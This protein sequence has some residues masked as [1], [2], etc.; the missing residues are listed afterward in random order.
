MKR[1]AEVEAAAAAWLQRRESAD[2]SEADDQS[3]AAWVAEDR[4]HHIAMLR[5][6][7]VWAK[8]DRL[9]VTGSHT[10]SNPDTIENAPTEW[11]NE[12]PRMTRLV[13]RWVWPAALAASIALLAVPAA[14]SLF[15]GEIYSTPVGGFQHVPLADGSQIDLNTD[16]H[17]TVEYSSTDRRISLSRG[18]AYF[19]VAKNAERPF[20]VE[21][22]DWRV[23]AV[24]TAFTVNTENENFG[25]IVTEG[26]VR[27]DRIG[28]A[29]AKDGPVYLSAGQALR[30]G[31]TS[32]T[33][34]SVRSLDARSMEAE[35][36]WREGLL[37]FEGRP[38]SEV[39]EEM[40]RYNQL[41][42][43]VDRSAADVKIDGSF[44]TTNAAGFIR[45]IEE[46]FDIQAIREGGQVLLIEKS[47]KHSSGVPE[48]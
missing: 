27:I 21:T 14:Q 24:G 11:D 12:Q 22:P 40:N 20:Y 42:M 18:E 25:V 33:T 47:K 4:A 1:A 39:A 30:L 43:R 8:V 19:K 45:L 36:G 9:R 37:T 23:T 38:L 46:G 5:L 2:W 13:K 31:P 10:S 7:S 29:G 32:N 34:S 17:L 35:L 15:S 3:L 28:G 16:S 48:K 6:S 44:R 41:Q 26:R